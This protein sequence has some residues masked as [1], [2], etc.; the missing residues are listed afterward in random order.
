MQ[1]LATNKK[2]LLEHDKLIKNYEKKVEN[3]KSDCTG[4]HKALFGVF[5]NSHKLNNFWF[6]L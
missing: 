4:M 3:L 5:G 2:T 6:S 1:F